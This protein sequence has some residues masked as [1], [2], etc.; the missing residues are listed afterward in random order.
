MRYFHE[1]QLEET[2]LPRDEYE[3]LCRLKPECQSP[4]GLRYKA[5]TDNED[6]DEF[7][8]HA[9]GI[10]KK[11]GICRT[12]HSSANSY[13]YSIMRNYVDSDFTA[14]EFLVLRYQRKLKGIDGPQ[15]DDTGRLLV[16]ASDAKPNL[17]FGS[18]Y[19]DNLIIVS[20][21]VRQFLEKEQLIGL[22]FL[23][24]AIKSKSSVAA[25]ELPWELDSTVTL[26]KIA[27]THKLIHHGP[28]PFEGDYSRLVLINDSPFFGAELHYR[29]SDLDAIGP[30]D[31]ANTLEKYR[32]SHPL[33]ISQRFYQHCKKNKI[34]LN[35]EPVR[36]DPG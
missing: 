32:T 26:P 23:P 33:V 30:F 19:P 24:V 16:L 22:R 12:M 5:I 35:V 21:T 8:L 1:F 36:I 18:T 10:L 27:N 34:S 17:K 28:Q 3:E 29:R 2:T 4:Y 25:P 6:G 9:I 7:I 15:R 13:G 14:S 11:R 20:D 31:L